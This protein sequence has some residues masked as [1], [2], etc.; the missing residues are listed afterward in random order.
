MAADCDKLIHIKLHG[1]NPAADL[2]HF[3]EDPEPEVRKQAL[4]YVKKVPSDALKKLV[5]DPEQEVAIFAINHPE[6]WEPHLHHACHW[7]Q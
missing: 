6:A 3:F 7:G 1:G 5:L 4:E 2:S